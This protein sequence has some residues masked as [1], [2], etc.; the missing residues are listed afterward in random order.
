[1]PSTIFVDRAIRASVIGP[2]TG[3]DTSVHYFRHAR[4]FATLLTVRCDGG[5]DLTGIGQFWREAGTR[6]KGQAAMGVATF[7][8]T[9]RTRF[10]RMS[11]FSL[12][13]ICLLVISMP[14]MWLHQICRS[15]RPGEPGDDGGPVIATDRQRVLVFGRQC[16][17]SRVDRGHLRPR[18]AAGR[19]DIGNKAGHQL[20]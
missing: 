7:R 18:L 13:Y 2:A 1:M 14:S 3:R 11:D 17:C 5:Y 15:S 8:D 6:V 4:T 10:C 12:P 19:V 20:N 9:I 16:I